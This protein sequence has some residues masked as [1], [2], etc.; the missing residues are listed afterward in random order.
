MIN[1]L[2][3]IIKYTYNKIYNMFNIF[4]T[5]KHKLLE[6]DDEYEIVNDILRHF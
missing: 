6:T 1:K 4:S 5:N 2:Y 3:K